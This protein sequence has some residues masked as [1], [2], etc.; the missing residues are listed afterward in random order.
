M[1]YKR[2]VSGLTTFYRSFAVC[3]SFL[4]LRGSF[5]SCISGCMFQEKS[6]VIVY[7]TRLYAFL[8][9]FFARWA[10][11]IFNVY[12]PSCV[13]LD[14]FMCLYLYCVHIVNIYQIHYL[15][16]FTLKPLLL[17]QF[18]LKNCLD[19]C[20]CVNMYIY[21]FIYIENDFVII[22][23]YINYLF[24][25]FI[26]CYLITVYLLSSATISVTIAHAIFAMLIKILY[27]YCDR[28]LIELFSMLY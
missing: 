10:M 11:F 17:W 5:L 21:I 8:L 23:T 13:T 3:V 25:L 7:F 18:I 20:R 28:T 24:L 16:L 27:S 14:I 22:F 12:L 2:Y 15:L 6:I 19:D 4:F 1:C 26:T 9:V